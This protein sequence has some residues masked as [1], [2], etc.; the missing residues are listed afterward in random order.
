[1]IERESGNANYKN[2]K[3]D[4]AIQNYT[5]CLAYNPRNPIILSNRAMAYLKNAQY[6]NAEIDCTSAIQLDPSH[7]KSYTRRGTARNALGKHRL[8]LI[9]FE[10]A[11]RLDPSS[12][13]V[14]GQIAKTREAL[15]GAIKR[16]PKTSIIPTRLASTKKEPVDGSDKEFIKLNRVEI[17]NPCIDD[18]LS[19]N[20]MEIKLTSDKTIDDIEEAVSQ[21]VPRTPP[22][23]S[24]E[25]Y[26]VWRSLTPRFMKQTQVFELAKVRY[27]S[28][29]HPARLESIFQGSIESDV[30]CEI[31]RLFRYHWN[32][33]KPNSFIKEF[34]CELPK[35]SRFRLSI[36]FLDTSDQENISSVVESVCAHQSNAKELR[37]LYNLP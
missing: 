36:M 29:L 4:A 35:I 14:E 16:A 27:L 11:R 19:K 33:F 34:V 22:K 32:E 30:L 3:Y 6:N 31:F 23:T 13:E 9:D 25:F 28:M 17:K 8:A 1:M 15:K 20:A 12:K 2:G 37:Q 21:L 5:L 26:R 7:L 10:I 24:Y 18:N